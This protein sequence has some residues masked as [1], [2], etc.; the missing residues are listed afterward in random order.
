MGNHYNNLFWPTTHPSKSKFHIKPNKAIDTL[1]HLLSICS[2]PH[3]KGFWIAKHNKVVHQIAH[4]LQSNIHTRS[5]I[6]INVGHQ[7]SRL[8]DVTILDW[9][10][11]C[12]GAIPPCICLARVRPYIS[13]L[14]IL[15]TPMDNQP[16]SH[17]IEFT[18]CHDRFPITAHNENN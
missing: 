9:L 14:C 6:L 17:T 1:P 13:I 16:P 2:N 7:N 15:G 3:I 5:F 10:L 12:I 11:Q 18:C 8:Q 4:T